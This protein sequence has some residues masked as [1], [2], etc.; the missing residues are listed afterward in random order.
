MALLRD[1]RDE[2]L[3][4]RR[5]NIRQ[6]EGEGFQDIPPGGLRLLQNSVP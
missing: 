4:L 5:I 2:G 1:I 6:V 3:L